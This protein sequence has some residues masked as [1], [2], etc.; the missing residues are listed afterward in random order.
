MTESRVEKSKNIIAA[1]KGKLEGKKVV[2]KLFALEGALSRKFRE[3]GNK[4][5]KFRGEGRQSS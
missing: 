1:K 3:A 5:E 2:S 4:G